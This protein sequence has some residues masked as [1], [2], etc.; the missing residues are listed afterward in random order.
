MVRAFF[1]QPPSWLGDAK[2][3]AVV[4][5]C[6]WSHPN[7]PV[8]SI[9]AEADGLARYVPHLTTQ[10]GVEPR[11][12]LMLVPRRDIANKLNRTAFVFQNDMQHQHRHSRSAQ[13]N[14]SGRFS[15][16]TCS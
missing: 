3:A 9:D 5:K 13:K 11:D 2:A 14:S 4:P 10:N 7:C 8:D 12:V 6:G 16:G 15:H 1:G